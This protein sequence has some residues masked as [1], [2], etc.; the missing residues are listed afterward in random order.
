MRPEG[1]AF[2][3]ASGE[4]FDVRESGADHAA[5]GGVEDDD[6]A[7]W[8]RIRGYRIFSGNFEKRNAKIQTGCRAGLLRVL[9]HDLNRIQLDEFPF[10]RRPVA[11]ELAVFF[12]GN[13]E[14][15]KFRLER[16]GG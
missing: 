12:A 1:I 8:L 13:P 15:G 2:E 7:V 9:P 6:D 4:F 16:S 10:E 14:A 5:V 3:G 11:R